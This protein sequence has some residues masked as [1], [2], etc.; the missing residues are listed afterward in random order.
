MTHRAAVKVD[1]DKINLDTKTDDGR[2]NT[3]LLNMMGGLK[4]EHLSDEERELCRRFG[5]DGEL[6][7]VA[8]QM[9]MFGCP[10]ASLDAMLNDTDDPM[11]LI[12]GMLSDVQ[13]CPHAEQ[14][15]MTLNKAKYLL[16]V[17]RARINLLKQSADALLKLYIANPDTDSEFVVTVT[18]TNEDPVTEWDE[19]RKV[20]VMF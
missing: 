3:L 7:A 16:D 15:R 2:F 20:L 5:F 9:G 12:M 18:P 17:M 13:D 11:M 1:L 10:A 8:K 6:T 14:K 19:F 4:W